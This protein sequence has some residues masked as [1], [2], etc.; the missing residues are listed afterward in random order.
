MEDKRDLL[1]QMFQ[2]IKHRALQPAPQK[3]APQRLPILAY[4]LNKWLH[5]LPV[6]ALPV[7]QGKVWPEPVIDLGQKPD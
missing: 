3:A 7:Q 6:L 4:S 1:G 2:M 5:R